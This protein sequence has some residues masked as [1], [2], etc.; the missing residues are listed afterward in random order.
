[1]REILTYVSCLYKQQEK[2]F[3]V[4]SAGAC[5]SQMYRATVNYCIA[6]GEQVAIYDDE[7]LPPTIRCTNCEM[8]LPSSSRCNQCK[9]Y[10]KVL[11]AMLHRS[12][13]SASTTDPTNPNSH[14]NYKTLSSPQ[15]IARLKNQH[16]QIKL[17]KQQI[18]RLTERLEAVIEA[19]G[20]TVQHELHNNLS[21]AM[22]EHNSTVSSAYPNGSFQRLF[23]DMQYKAM[24]LKNAKSMRWQP[25]M[26]R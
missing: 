21:A 5:V 7:F 12:T 18:K 17:Q 4:N 13:S 14:T 9:E 15:K 22:E 25:A 20:I 11:T 6:V 23:W 19:T 1:M 8:L 10:R 16:D 26:I 2:V 24:K 3:F